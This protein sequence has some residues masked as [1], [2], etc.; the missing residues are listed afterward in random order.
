M[1]YIENIVHVELLADEIRLL[2]KFVCIARGNACYV[3]V[4]VLTIWGGLVAAT[5]VKGCYQHRGKLEISMHVRVS[6]VL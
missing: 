2:K 5:I 4:V 6:E 1:N 3:E